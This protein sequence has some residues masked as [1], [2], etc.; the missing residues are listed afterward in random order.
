[1]NT[2]KKPVIEVQKFEANE[3]VAACFQLACTAMGNDKVPMY[4]H[5]GKICN[6]HSS[7]YCGNPAHQSLSVANGVLSVKEINASN[8]VSSTLHT[9]SLSYTDNDRNGVPSVGDAV[10]WA[11]QADIP[12]IRND[13]VWH[14]SGKLT[15]V[16][17]KYPNRS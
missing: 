14:H 9:I 1:M 2:W 5:N 12:G 6:T 11:N 8:E 7:Q 3:Y 13:V 16:D 10:E 4:G 15:A 17:T